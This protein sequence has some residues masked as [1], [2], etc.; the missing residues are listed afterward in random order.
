[1]SK[2]R[3]LFSEEELQQLLQVAEEKFPPEQFQ[4][5]RQI[6]TSYRRLVALIREGTTPIE[7][8]REMF[9]VKRGPRTEV[10]EDCDTGPERTPSP[11]RDGRADG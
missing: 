8:L 11:E 5:V 4:V 6:I 3:R 9:Q 2:K 10:G 1:M 7:R